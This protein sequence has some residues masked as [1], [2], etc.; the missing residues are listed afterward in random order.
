MIVGADDLYAPKAWIEQ[1]GHDI[2]YLVTFKKLRLYLVTHA[3]LFTDMDTSSVAD[4]VATLHNERKYIIIHSK[5][6]KFSNIPD[7]RGQQD[8]HSVHEFRKA[9]GVQE[10][11]VQL[12]D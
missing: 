12:D 11:A 8:L 9:R 10:R 1:S 3:Y 5:A 2:E 7:I 4:I 6:M